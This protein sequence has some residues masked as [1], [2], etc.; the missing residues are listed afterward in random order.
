MAYVR[1][2]EG[3]GKEEDL[4]VELSTFCLTLFPSPVFYSFLKIHLPKSF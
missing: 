3:E 4:K 2:E 1:T